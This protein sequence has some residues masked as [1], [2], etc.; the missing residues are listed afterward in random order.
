[1]SKSKKNVVDLDAFI[2]DFGADVA[3]WFVLSDSPP[4]RDVEWTAS[5]VKGAW[6]F[7]QRVWTLVEAHGRPAPKPGDAAP[8]R[9]Q[10]R[11]CAG[12]APAGAPRRAERHR[13]HRELPLQRR[14]RALLRTGERHRQAEGRRRRRR[15]RAR[16][17]AAHPGAAHLAVH[18]APGRG[19]LGEARASSRS[20][21][22]RPGRSPIP[23]WRRGRRLRC[24]SR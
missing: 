3:R 7:V 21:P 15:V 17:G 8:R 14:G 13:R 22:P 6:G 18:A 5:G 20:S 11:R 10:R 4:E 1:M 19:V 2:T 23:R 16:R 9:R 24:R 12:A